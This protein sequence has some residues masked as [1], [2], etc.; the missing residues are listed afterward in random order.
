MVLAVTFAVILLARRLPLRVA[1]VRPLVEEFL[2]AKSFKICR[3][4]D[5]VVEGCVVN[6]PTLTNGA[7]F[8]ITLEEPDCRTFGEGYLSEVLL[9]A[10]CRTLWQAYDKL[11]V[12][13]I[14]TKIFP[15]ARVLHLLPVSLKGS[16][17]VALKLE[18]IDP[19][20]LTD[21]LIDELLGHHKL[22]VHT[23]FQLLDAG[24]LIEDAFHPPI[25]HNGD[26]LF[27]VQV[28]GSPFLLL[29][30]NSLSLQ[31]HEGFHICFLATL[32]ELGPSFLV[33]LLVLGHRA[34]RCSQC[35]QRVFLE[36]TFGRV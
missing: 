32:L 7:G 9:D 25:E 14:R 23:S 10:E 17:R 26:V 30:K 22:V 11:W 12:Q 19:A 34:F 18:M 5:D 2:K 4:G 36:V 31:G 33:R 16:Q 20:A 3:L 24:I 6:P 29:S 13:V 15:H 21:S 28:E 27:G 1:R 35:A 8:F